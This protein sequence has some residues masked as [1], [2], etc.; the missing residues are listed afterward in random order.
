MQPASRSVPEC[1]DSE[2]TPTEPLC[3]PTRSFSTVRSPLVSTES[4]A[5]FSLCRVASDIIYAPFRL[6]IPNSCLLLSYAN[7]SLKSA[8]GDYTYS[9]SSRSTFRLRLSKG[10]RF[11]SIAFGDLSIEALVIR[12]AQQLIKL[13]AGLHSVDQALLC[14]GLFQHVQRLAS[15]VHHHAKGCHRENH[16]RIAHLGKLLGTKIGRFAELRHVGHEGG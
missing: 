4:R 5:A 10:R 9:I 11:L 14:T 3:S 8:P 15:R 12:I 6:R 1:S 7:G 13:F 2:R 16:H